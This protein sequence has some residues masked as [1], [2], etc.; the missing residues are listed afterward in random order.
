MQH[1]GLANIGFSGAAF[2]MLGI[3]LFVYLHLR[4][5]QS[6]RNALD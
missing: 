5:G 3:G 4:Y 2:A 6:K 1:L